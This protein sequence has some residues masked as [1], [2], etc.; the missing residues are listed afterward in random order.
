MGC[1]VPHKNKGPEAKLPK[2][3]PLSNWNWQSEQCR[4]NDDCAAH[5]KGLVTRG[6]HSTANLHISASLSSVAGHKGLLHYGYAVSV[7]T[8]ERPLLA[9]KPHLRRRLCVHRQSLPAAARTGK[10][11]RWRSG[12]HTF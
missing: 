8:K 11:D 3:G 6:A 9:P 10:G 4:T 1:A 2:E 5:A 7:G 12:A